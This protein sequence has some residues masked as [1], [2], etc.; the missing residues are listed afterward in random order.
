MKRVLQVFLFCI[1]FTV[2]S[3]AQN[4]NAQIIRQKYRLDIGS[5]N[6][7]VRYA[8]FSP[9]GKKVLL[10]NENSTQVWSA[11]TGKL[12]LTF[13]EKISLKDG[14]ALKW[15]P[16][17]TKILQY[18]TVLL[19]KNSAAPLWDIE[20]GKLIAVMNETRGVKSAEWNRSGDRILTVGDYEY[21][22]DNKQVSLSIRDENGKAVRT[23]SIRTFSLLSIQFASDGNNII[24]SYRVDY[25]Y[26]FKEKPIRI[27]DA[28]TGALLRSYDQELKKLSS[29]DYAVFRAESPDGKFVCGQIYPSKGAT[30]W[31]NAGSESPLYYFLDSKQTG[32]ISFLSFSPDSKSFAVSK[33]KQKAIEIVEAETGKVR[34]SLDNPNKARL[35]FYPNSP[36]YAASGD[37]WSPTGKFFIATDFE[38]EANIWNAETGRLVAKLPVI[39]GDDWDWFVGTLVSDYETFYFHRSEKILLSVSN[40]VVRLWKPETG[41]LLQEIKETDKSKSKELFQRFVARWSPAGNL[42]MT[43]AN[44]NKS[45]LLWEVFPK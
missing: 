35:N 20:S 45:V 25:R 15:Q 5:S 41:E 17:G 37:S 21:S 3:Y 11:E 34:V 32:D 40:K 8:L 29:F 36:D 33:P 14:D 13:A 38:K 2:F 30:C 19:D 4:S 9:N 27:Y 26:D 24:E 42:L 7:R 28:D 23:D 18:K 10:V 43:A 44:E 12:L 39:Y 31:K 22:T 1:S 6:D 16:N